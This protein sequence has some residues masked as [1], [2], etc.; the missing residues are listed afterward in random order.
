MLLRV[1]VDDVERRIVHPRQVDVVAG[2]ERQVGWN[3]RSELAQRFQ[4][5]DGELVVAR[6]QRRRRLAQ[7]EQPANGGVPGLAGEPPAHDEPAVAVETELRSEAPVRGDACAAA[8]L[9]LLARDHADP[10]MAQCGEMAESLPHSRRVVRAD[11]VRARSR[12]LAIEEHA[13]RHAG[14]PLGQPRRAL[15]RH[16]GDQPVDPPLA[17]RR[18]ELRL[19][20]GVAPGVGQHERVAVRVQHGIGSLRDRGEDRVRDVR[21]DEADRARR[22]RA[23]A[24]RR[25]V[26]PVI[27]GLHR[28]GHPLTGAGADE[29]IVVED[30]RDRR[31]GDLRPLGDLFD[32][33]SHG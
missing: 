19:V 20:L 32:R 10:R 27:E 4:R 22:A 11:G 3:P 12:H 26:R 16:R 5:A 28:V 18:D 25:H 21:D 6:D 13:R 33:R 7:P 2:D 1:A 9:T 31:D 23:H 8:E 24:A 29:R 17:E 15:V 14:K 30:A